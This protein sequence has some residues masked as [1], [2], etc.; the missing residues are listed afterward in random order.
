MNIPKTLVVGINMHGELHF[1]ES[2]SV[3]KD[4]IPNNFRVTV[5]NAVAP[6]VP[7]IS[8][9]E[10]TEELSEKIYNRIKRRKHWNKLTKT[11][12]DDL[13]ENIKD[14]LVNTNKQQSKDII[15]EHQRLY[16]KNKVNKSFQNYVHNYDHS[17]KITSYD[18]GDKIPDKLYLKFQEGEVLI[19]DDVE[20][21][22]FN[23]IILFNLEGEPDIFEILQSVGMD[24]DQITTSQLIEFLS[25]LGVENLI[26]IDLSCSVFK[27]NSK[28]LTE[29]NIRYTRRKI[30]SIGNKSRRNRNRK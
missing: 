8:T 24:I 12:I 5:I 26:M 2:G 21:K 3:K 28:H 13:A 4:V 22:Y 30:M 1:T 20:E 25:S 17:F 7:N 18:S 6:G 14:L 19:P 9:F 15:R 11:Q 23:S 29:R 16:S 10:K 27:G